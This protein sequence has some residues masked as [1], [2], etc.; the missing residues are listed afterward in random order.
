MKLK[1]V[2]FVTL[3]I[4]NYQDIT[5]RAL[6]VLKAVD[7]YIGETLKVAKKNLDLLQIPLNEK[8]LFTIK[9]YP[10]KEEQEDFLKTLLLNYSALAFL[11]DVGMPLVADPGSD[12]LKLLLLYNIEPVM[13]GG[14]SSVN[15]ALMQA[16]FPLDNYYFAGFLSRKEVER[17]HQLHQLKFIKTT[18]VIMESHHRLPTILLSLKKHFSLQL[19]V[20]LGF[21]LTIKTEKHFRGTLAQAIKKFTLK[22]NYEP[23]VLIINNRK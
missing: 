6:E 15:L 16:N 10:T 13:V 12:F 17:K 9:D 7:G 20:Y 18:I 22:K 19:S 2:Y 1:K 11:V 8:P 5:L 4:G 14:V 21:S 3:P 23:F